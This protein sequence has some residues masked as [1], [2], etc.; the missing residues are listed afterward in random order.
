[1]LDDVVAVPPDRCEGARLVPQWEADYRTYIATRR[2]YA[3]QLRETGE[4][5]AFYETGGR[6]DPDERTARD[7]R[8]R[9]RDAHVRS[10]ARPGQLT[11]SGALVA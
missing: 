5:L 4:N 3:E 2:V 9:Q 1:M 7:V 11:G 6:F 8:R 10:A